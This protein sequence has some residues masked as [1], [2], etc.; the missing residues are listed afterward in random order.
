MN[1]LRQHE[2]LKKNPRVDAKIPSMMKVNF[3]HDIFMPFYWQRT[4]TPCDVASRECTNFRSF[5]CQS[6]VKAVSKKRDKKIIILPVGCRAF[7][8][9]SLPPA[10]VRP[11]IKFI[12]RFA[13]RRYIQIH[14][15][16]KCQRGTLFGC[17]PC[18]ISLCFIFFEIVTCTL[19]I[20]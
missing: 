3:M 18:Q 10:Q 9:C 20:L 6:T 14:C 1:D 15:K 4:S 19:Y 16:S 17:Y 11:I 7:L 12:E 2:C 8:I 5:M 13:C